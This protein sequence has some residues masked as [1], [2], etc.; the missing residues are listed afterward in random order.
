M[1]LRVMTK[2]DTPSALAISAGAATDFLIGVGD[3]LNGMAFPGNALPR[4]SVSLDRA[5][6]IKTPLR[7]P[8]SRGSRDV[9]AAV[10]RL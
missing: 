4:Q 10:Q 3:F 2:A 6:R 8:D 5:T 9:P 1:S 7:Y